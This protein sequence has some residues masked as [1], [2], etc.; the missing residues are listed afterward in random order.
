MKYLDML[1][2]IPGVAVCLERN[3][4]EETI[5]NLIVKEALRFYLNNQRTEGY[6]YRRIRLISEKLEEYAKRKV[7]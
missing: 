6:S 7:R 5:E 2:N 3:I 1:K 4:P